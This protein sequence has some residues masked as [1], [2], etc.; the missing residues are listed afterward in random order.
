MKISAEMQAAI[1]RA[2]KEKGVTRIEPGVSGLKPEEK[3]DPQKAP[4]KALEK[5]APRMTKARHSETKSARQER[6]RALRE[7]G[8][9][10]REMSSILGVST[11]T[12]TKDIKAL[13]LTGEPVTRSWKN[14]GKPK[15]EVG[16]NTNR[17]E[18]VPDVAPDYVVR[19]VSTEELER[20]LNRC[21]KNVSA[22]SKI[23]G[24]VRKELERR[25][26]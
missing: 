2:V 9:S 13:G 24:V 22:I 7:Q 10:L 18:A 12:I 26:V 21:E 19:W 1:D 3:P 5:E 11:V 8:K 17:E 4:Q 14:E 16:Q 25:K 15:S 6:V 23:I 20:I